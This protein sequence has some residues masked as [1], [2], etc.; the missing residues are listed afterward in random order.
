MRVESKRTYKSLLLILCIAV[1]ACLFLTKSVNMQRESVAPRN[2]FLCIEVAR[3]RTSLPAMTV[4]T[5]EHI[6]TEMV[7]M[8]EFPPGLLVSP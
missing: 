4:I 2:T 5:L 8:N 6:K 7:L 1:C 3:A